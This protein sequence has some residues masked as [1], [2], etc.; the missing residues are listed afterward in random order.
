[1]CYDVQARPPYPPISGGAGEGE[2]LILEAGDGTRFAAYY[3]A[4]SQDKGAQIIILPDVR[5]LHPF[6]KELA[7]RFAEVGIRAIAIDYFGRTAGITARD[8]EF[9]YQP[10]VQQMQ[11]PHVVAD[12][13]AARTFLSKQDPRKDVTFTVGFCRGGTLSLLL[14]A[15]DLD[16]AGVI[17]FY[18]GFS[19]P[20]PGAEDTLQRSKKIHVP[21][22][23]LYGGTDQSITAEQVQEL[24]INLDQAGVKHE[25]ITYPGAP[26]SFFDRRYKEHADASADA[27]T[28]ILNFIN[29]L[30]PKA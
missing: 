16:L 21:V 25:V 22:L 15:E 27:W 19:R 2:D 29:S 1:M 6:Y 13:K 9:D 12:V 4:P 24:D 3:A 11:F 20:V 18:S 17:A 7:L 30:T 14:G 28:R 26:H 23:G 8:D 10:H 5:G